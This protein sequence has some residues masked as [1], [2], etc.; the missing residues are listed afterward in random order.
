MA[1][2]CLIIKLPRCVLS[3]LVFGVEVELRDDACQVSAARSVES[4]HNCIKCRFNRRLR[5]LVRGGRPDVHRKA[6]SSQTS[7]QSQGNVFRVKSDSI[8][9]AS[10]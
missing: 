3:A 9:A 10:T 5:L 8:D 4:M 1:R 6:K 2:M 7:S